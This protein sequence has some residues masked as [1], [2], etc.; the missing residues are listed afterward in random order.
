MSPVQGSSHK[1]YQTRYEQKYITVYT[2]KR[3]IKIEEEC[4]NAYKKK[5]I[6]HRNRIVT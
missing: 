3:T 4:T 5:Y 6:I 1:R 2:K